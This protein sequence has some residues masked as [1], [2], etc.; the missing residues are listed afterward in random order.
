[1]CNICVCVCVGGWGVLVCKVFIK[2][3]QVFVFFFVFPRRKHLR[4]VVVVRM[5]E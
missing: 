3:R 5:G 4:E 2:A 1:M